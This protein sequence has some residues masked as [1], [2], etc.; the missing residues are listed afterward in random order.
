MQKN[1]RHHVFS[2]FISTIFSSSFRR[3]GSPLGEKLIRLLIRQAL[4]YFFESPDTNVF[5]SSSLSSILA[6][7]YT[8]VVPL[9]SPLRLFLFL[10]FNVRIVTI[11]KNKAMAQYMSKSAI[12]LLK[13]RSSRS[14]HVWNS[15]PSILQLNELK[16]PI[17]PSKQANNNKESG[18]E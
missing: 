8:I 9:R 15:P 18:E 4:R 2:F 11:Y 5:A 10:S 17:P 14:I 12:T 16:N 6:T 7:I 3:M 1:E 13:S